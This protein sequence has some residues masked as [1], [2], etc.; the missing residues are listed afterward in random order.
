MS[1][2]LYFKIKQGT[3][4]DKAVKEHFKLR[5]L[6]TNV[7]PLVSE[8]LSEQI[9]RIA[10]HPDDLYI[11]T[12]EIKNEENKKL[13]N[14]EGKLKSNTKRAKEIH[15]EY[16]R[17]IQKVGLTEFRDLGTI[18]FIYGVMRLSGE[19][20]KSYRTSDDDIYYEC[21]FDLEKRSNGLVVPITEIEYQEKYLE[22]LKK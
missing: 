17:I 15:E 16:K 3:K 22:E 6:W 13:F 9:T 11:D 21:D 8:L 5:K 12:S 14:R 18:N 1:D 7:F 19:H 20:L 10:R 4:Y 2:K